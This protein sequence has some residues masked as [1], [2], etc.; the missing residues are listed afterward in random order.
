MTHRLEKKLD[1][2]PLL[3]APPMPKTAPALA[4]IS[5][6]KLYRVARRERL[7]ERLYDCRQRP[8]ISAS[9]ALIGVLLDRATAATH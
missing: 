2:G 9:G 5:R 4:K 1:N 3:R 6:P 8:I 7:F